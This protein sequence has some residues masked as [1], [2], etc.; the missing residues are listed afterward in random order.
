V[1][2][3]L[4]STETRQPRLDIGPVRL[5][6]NLVL[7]P[8]AQYCDLAWRIACRECGGVG[9]ACTDLLSPHGLLKGGAK[10]M[11]L[12][13]TNELDSPVCMQLYGNDP[14]LLAEAGVWAV[15][16]G[17]AVIDINMGCPVDKVV[18]KNGG[19]MLL[20]DPA[21]T[22][23]LAEAIVRAV[24]RASHGRVPV[25]AKMRLG[26]DDS[27]IV[28]PDLARA[29]ERI[30]I[31]AVTVHGRT[32]EMKFTGECRRA[33]IRDVVHAVDRIPIL[34]NGD[35]TTPEDALSMIAE[36]GCAGVMIGR[37]SF[38]RPWIFRRAWSL[39]TTDDAG[40][41]PTEAEK[42]AI[43]RRYFRLM[44]ELRTEHYALHHM[45]R[46]MSWFAKSLGPCKPLH[47]AVRTAACAGDVERALD[48]FEAGGL[49]AAAHALTMDESVA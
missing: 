48:A 14:D 15:G 37:G 34:G 31:A 8:V 10:S 43:M 11:D 9:L 32:T 49:R 45:R 12:A 5:A 47:E 4:P 30:G 18:K 29:L 20:C 3:R 41:E 17:A 19:S 44:V 27:C 46:R 24:D 33:G 1:I 39:L 13:E 28:A 2:A 35:V 7:A 23:G 36:T 21:R 42:L 40:P 25:T 22:V 6:T 26:W 16:H 38:S